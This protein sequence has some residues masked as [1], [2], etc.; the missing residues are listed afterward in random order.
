MI[1]CRSMICSRRLAA[2]CSS[3]P[4]RNASYFSDG[5]SSRFSFLR[6]MSPA[7]DLSGARLDFLLLEL[8]LLGGLSFGRSLGEGHDR[9]RDD[10]NEDGSAHECPGQESV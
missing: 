8:D 10:G 4:V 3:T 9:E 7:S 5:A 2:T 6:V 1:F